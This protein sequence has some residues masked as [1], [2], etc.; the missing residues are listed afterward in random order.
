MKIQLHVGTKGE[1]R[2]RLQFETFLAYEIVQTAEILEKNGL[3]LQDFRRYT[4]II[5]NNPVKLNLI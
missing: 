4:Y 1:G 5:F 2:S 3:T